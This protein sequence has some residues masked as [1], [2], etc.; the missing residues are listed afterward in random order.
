M[1]CNADAVLTHDRVVKYATLA[2]S[3]QFS[4]FWRFWPLFVFPKN[5]RTKVEYHTPTSNSII[6][7]SRIKTISTLAKRPL[8]PQKSLPLWRFFETISGLTSRR[9]ITDWKAANML[10]LYM[11]CSMCIYP[12]VYIE[13]EREKREREREREIFTLASWA[14]TY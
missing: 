1:Q 4:K 6:V 11:Y 13:R 14:S 3:D 12:N 7:E 5:S 8:I 2:D 10:S 9:I